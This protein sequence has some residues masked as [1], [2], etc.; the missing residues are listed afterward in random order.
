A[1]A[2][3][4]I[5]RPATPWHDVAPAAAVIARAQAEGTPVVHQGNSHNRFRFAGRLAV[6]LPELRGEELSQ[7][8]CHH[9]DGLIV[10]YARARPAKVVPSVYEQPLRGRWLRIVRAKDYQAQTCEG[11]RRV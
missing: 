10:T 9:P 5:M 2:A 1:A 3:V 8:A 6:P 4:G 11:R 7:W